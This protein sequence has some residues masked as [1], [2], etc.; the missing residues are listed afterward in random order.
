MDRFMKT[1]YGEAPNGMHK[2]HGGPFGAVIVKD[3]QIIAKGHNE[4][5]FSKDPSAHAE[6]VTIRKACK[7]LNT[8]DLS[9]CTLYVTSKPCPMCKGAIQWSRIKTVVFSGDYKDAEKLNFEDQTFSDG[10]D[11]E[12]D[13]WIQ[14]DE[15][16][17]ETLVDAFE[18]YKHEIRY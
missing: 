12:D 14:V 5:L 4:V 13:H 15:D 10:F 1:A 17:F 16:Q 6:V 2:K 8:I 9:D 18:S 11:E 7:K 3:N